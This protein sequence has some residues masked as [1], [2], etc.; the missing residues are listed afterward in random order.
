MNHLDHA[1]QL[2]EEDLR[3]IFDIQRFEV[4]SIR[5]STDWLRRE[6][7]VVDADVGFE[8]A[9]VR[10][11]VDPRRGRVLERCQYAYPVPY[12]DLPLIGADEA[13]A[14]ARAEVERRGW[15]WEGRVDAVLRRPWFGRP[16]WY[17]RTN[18]DFR[19][20]N[21]EVGVDARTKVV[22]GRGYMPR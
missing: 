16:W 6:R 8:L 19:G 7:V 21:A 4:V 5:R 13:R 20:R 2:A 1:T 10:V 12:D 17:V 11:V 3:R 18:V 9:R 14:L 15:R 22:V